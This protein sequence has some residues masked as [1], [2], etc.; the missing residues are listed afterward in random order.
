MSRRR[1]ANSRATALL[2]R[3]LRGGRARRPLRG[4]LALR[5]APVAADIAVLAAG[6]HVH[7]VL[8]IGDVAQPAHRRGI[9]PRDA[10]RAQH[11]LDAVAQLELHT[12]PVDEVDLLLLVV[13]MGTARVA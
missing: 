3:A 6:A 10:A 11:V 9:H 8:L 13:V 1:R 5:P 2:W 4:R 7:G 12:P